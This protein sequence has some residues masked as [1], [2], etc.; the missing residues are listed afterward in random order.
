MIADMGLAYVCWFSLEANNPVPMNYK[1]YDKNTDGKAN[2]A[3]PFSETR[4]KT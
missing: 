3:E 4:Y 1:I 2:A